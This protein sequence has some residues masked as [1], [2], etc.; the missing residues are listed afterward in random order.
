MEKEFIQLRVHHGGEVM[1]I[2][3]SHD[4]ISTV[5]KMHASAQFLFS[6]SFF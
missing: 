6:F 2:S 1:V 4:V 5:R 3:W